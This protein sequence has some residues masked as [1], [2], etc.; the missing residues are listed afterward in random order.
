MER[1]RIEALINA[2]FEHV[3]THISHVFVGEES[4]WKVK[5]AVDFGFLDFS[6]PAK[7]RAACDD[8][9]R[10]N[11]RLVGDVY[12]GVG[13][14]IDSGDGPRFVT[15]EEANELEDE[16]LGDAARDEPE[17]AVLMRR[18]R[19]DDRADLLLARGRLD[20]AALE[21]VAV[22]LA[23]FHAAARSDE[24][25]RRYGRLAAVRR[26]IE[27]NFEQTRDTIAE[28]FDAE[29]AAEL[30][31]RQR[32]EMA[33]HEGLFAAR[34][35]QGR[36][37]EGHG[38]LRLDH[39]YL[40]TGPEG[41]ERI[42]IVDCIEF[43]ERLRAVDVACDIA[44]LA[45]DL[46]VAGRPDLAERFLAAYARAAGDFDLYALV[47]F[48]ESYRAHVRA[49]IA[50]FVV[51][52][53]AVPRR[54][55]EAKHEEARRH[56]LLALASERRPLRPPRL[57]AVGGVI[58]SGKSTIAR[59]VAAAL[60][61][62]SLDAD[63]TRKRLLGVDPRASLHHAPFAGAY[64][65]ETTHRI[66]TELLRAARIVLGSGRSLVVD[67]TFRSR[68]ERARFRA[69]AASLGVPFVLVECC[70][71]PAVC[72]ARLERRASD[73]TAGASDGR[74]EIFDEF[75]ASWQPVD[76]L[77]A[78]EHVIVDTERP[79]VQTLPA[80]EARLGLE[81]GLDRAREHA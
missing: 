8:E 45:M 51:A 13:A 39:V 64:T 47:D 6:S 22:R 59:A 24:A 78:A 70:C 26:N 80:L 1:E 48:Y 77:P 5:K 40:E 29:Q 68:G 61:A 28:H 38:D 69:L 30:A 35:E 67:A 34:V 49:K 53:P 12:R 60:D 65:T 17:P 2:G 11:R 20:A 32:A 4:V 10:L 79:L 41:D 50:S 63:S 36:V 14:L 62:P 74:L 25:I 37:V 58:A 27:E 23:A 3:E 56:Y 16:V 46:S 76:E 55:R 33:R 72:R 81:V 44:F 7:R 57:I 21:R 43:S 71:S 42:T 52:D 66:Y 9:V 31:R 18:L 15:A 73:D 19:E 54:V 75:I